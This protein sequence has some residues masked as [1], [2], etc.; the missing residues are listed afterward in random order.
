MGGVPL[1]PEPDRMTRPALAVALILV[2]A[3]TGAAQPPGPPAPAPAEGAALRGES[4]PTR[5]RLAEAEAKLLGGKARDAADDL[6]RVLDE[7]GD[8]LVAA[9]GRQYRPARWVA[10]QLLAK[11]PPDAVAVVQQLLL[12]FPSDVR[13]YWLLA[14]LYAADGQLAEAQSILDEVAWSRQYGNRTKLMD[15]RAAVTAEAEARRPKPPDVPIS[16]R[17]VLVYFGAVAAVGVLALVRALTRGARPSPG[18]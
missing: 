9:D 18:R 16:L 4:P 13:L 7:A 14:E 2:G 15:H 8:D 12:W 3:A 1:G 6:L 17:T 10:H 11:L 5:K